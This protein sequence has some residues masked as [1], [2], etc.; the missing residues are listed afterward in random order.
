ML[1]WAIVGSG[2][3]SH[4][5]LKAIALSEGSRADLIIGR[6]ADSRRD[7]QKTYDIARESDDLAALQ[8]PNIDAVYIGLP[9]HLHR[10]VGLAALAAGKA[11]LCEKS[12]TVSMADARA[13]AAGAAESA[14]FFAEGL[15]Y[16][17]HPLYQKLMLLLV[18]PK[19]GE[20]RQISGF[21][22]AD[23]WQVVN[24]LGGG[25]L[26]NLGCYPVSLMHLVV[27]TM[28]GETA[29]AQRQI[30]AVGNKTA[31]GSLCDAAVTVRFDNG[32]LAT[33][34]SSDSHGF[35]HGFVITT[36][37]G[38]LQFETNPWLP[39]PGIN[40]FV[41]TSYSGEVER[42]TVKDPHDAFYHQLKMVENG[43]AEGQNQA[44]RPSPRV[45]DSLEIMAFLTEWVQA[46][47]PTS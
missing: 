38:T 47:D 24:P 32:V 20:L 3:I 35:S 31:E 21:Y 18:D 43:V 5:M 2:F 11:V 33:L 42:Y 22:A 12:L 29:F 26:F 4:A 44:K 9:N 28:C 10:E 13:F 40:S 45:G 37:T 19:L 25:T 34:Q 15:M 6:N 1:R 46:C 30:G 8:D 41:W 36:S 17:A 14:P 23:I 16:L 7:L 27:Q 39:E